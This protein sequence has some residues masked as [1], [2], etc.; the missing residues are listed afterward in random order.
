MPSFLGAGRAGVTLVAL[1]VP[2]LLALGVDHAP[3]PAS[4]DAALLV[5]SLVLTAWYSPL[6][7]HVEQVL[8]RMRGITSSLY[9]VVTM[10]FGIGIGPF[11]V[12]TTSDANGGNLAG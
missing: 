3:S 1:G 10:L 9:I 5:L 11:L 8:P 6:R 2:P 12:A 4:F 7:H